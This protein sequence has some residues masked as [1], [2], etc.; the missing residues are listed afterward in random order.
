MPGQHE[1]AGFVEAI[2]QFNRFY[3]RQIGILGEGYLRSPFTLT[4]VRVLYELAHHERA[5]ASHLARELALDPGYLSRL[6]AAFQRRGLVRRQHSAEDR[7]QRLLT[8]T[9]RGQKAFAQLNT[10]SRNEIESLLAPLARPNRKQL[11]QAMRSIE[12]LLGGPEEHGVPY[13]LRPPQAGDMGW[14]VHRHGALYAQEY[15]WNAEFEALVAQ[16]AADF[17]RNF[18]PERERAW[19]AE[20]GGENVGSVLL[21]RHPKRRSV[22]KLRLLLVE[23]SARGLGIGR[24]LVQECARFARSVGYRRITLWTNSVLV[25]ARR[26]Y[27]Q[28]GYRLIEEQPHESFGKKLIAQTWELD[29]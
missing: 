4:E 23:P 5:T 24:R 20:R 28:E 9:D 10:A 2:R 22:A 13:V 12:R 8:L 21:V 26:I 14:I 15:G 16:I 17:I 11:V 7:R 25:T 29:L 19:I 3:T 27:E 1:H 18:E 6:L